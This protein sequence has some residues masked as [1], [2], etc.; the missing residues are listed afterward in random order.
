[1]SLNAR[2]NRILVQVAEENIRIA[3]ARRVRIR[4]LR[5]ELRKRAAEEVAVEDPTTEGVNFQLTITHD[6]RQ[7]LADLGYSKEDV[8]K[9]KP[10]EAADIIK[11]GA[12]KGK[13]EMAAKRREKVLDQYEELTLQALEKAK[14]KLQSLKARRQKTQDA[15][16]L[17]WE[18][19]EAGGDDKSPQA[20]KRAVA[21]EEMIEN[22]E[23]KLRSLDDQ[24]Q[25][26]DKLVQ[27]IIQ[28]EDGLIEELQELNESAAATPTPED[29]KLLEQLVK[30]KVK[31]LAE[32]AKERKV[33]EKA[34]NAREQKEEHVFNAIRRKQ[35]LFEGPTSFD[36][37]MLNELD[38]ELQLSQKELDAADRDVQKLVRIVMQH[39]RHLLDKQTE[40]R[41][42]EVE[43]QIDQAHKQLPEFEQ[44]VEESKKEIAEE[45]KEPGKV[46]FYRDKANAMKAF[47][48]KIEPQFRDFVTQFIGPDIP[49]DPTIE[50]ALRFA[51]ERIIKRATAM[52]QL[53]DRYR[54]N[55][56]H[57]SA[58]LMAPVLYEVL[59]RNMDAV[60]ADVEGAKEARFRAAE[61]EAI[62]SDLVEAG[63][64]KEAISFREMMEKG[65]DIGK[66]TWEK[67][68]ELS[69]QA[70]EGIDKL[71]F[72]KKDVGPRREFDLPREQAQKNLRQLQELERELK[73]QK[74]RA[75]NLLKEQ[76]DPSQMRRVRDAIRTLD[77]KIRNVGEQKNVVEEGLSH[78][79]APGMMKGVEQ[80]TRP[81]KSDYQ[82]AVILMQESLPDLVQ[83]FALIPN[84]A[85]LE[86]ELLRQSDRIAKMAHKLI[87]IA[88][89]A[90]KQYPNL[91]PTMQA[92]GHMFIAIDDALDRALRSNEG[93]ERA[94]SQ[95]PAAEPK[96]ESSPVADLVDPELEAL[97]R[98]MDEAL[99]EQSGQAA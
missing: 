98:E 62:F 88:F 54:R 89:K 51:N 82:Q 16:P 18:R 38:D 64:L 12:T 69:E 9:L 86:Q 31:D 20:H 49:A 37:H 46:R 65:K 33:L 41:I 68:K 94:I 77:D 67:T 79:P 8:K 24:I 74:E 14:K 34:Q 73:L 39:E 60:L 23:A 27:R 30:E 87:Q 85:K 70:M 32:I 55:D 40:E 97:A 78:Q 57:R 71:R 56:M 19:H 6:M 28:S 7:Q 95:A 63:Y 61:T 72:K 45:D 21:F 48:Q 76:Q 17:M 52:Q 83:F 93:V 50:K 96:E 26:Q 29:D 53:S 11:D 15:I 66:R 84:D 47:V 4:E 43:Q 13:V 5:A 58:I 59:A 35:K 42:H 3:R 81:S 2:Y 10:Q 75:L 25:A 44:V 36:L 99:A 22:A 91:P 92:Y 80:A 90:K 1:M